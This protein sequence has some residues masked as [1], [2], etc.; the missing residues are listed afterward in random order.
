M[1]GHGRA[2]RD[3]VLE[4]LRQ[5]AG[6]T[7][8]AGILRVISV[9][10]GAVS[11]LLTAPAVGPVVA[12]A[13]FFA[14]SILLQLRFRRTVRSVP[15]AA[16]T[17]REGLLSTTLEHTCAAR[18]ALA[19]GGA[20]ARANAV[21]DNIHDVERGFESRSTCNSQFA[22]L[23][24]DGDKMVPVGT[25]PSTSRYLE[26]WIVGG[27]LPRAS[28]GPRGAHRDAARTL[29]VA[30][31]PQDDPD[32]QRLTARGVK[33]IAFVPIRRASYEQAEGIFF[34]TTGASFSSNILNHMAINANV[35]GGQLAGAGLA[36]GEL[37]TVAGR[38]RVHA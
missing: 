35:L 28:L 32:R 29:R 7:I 15:D 4:A 9:A 8:A 20:P 3:T 37:E 25:A 2:A 22:T 11:S 27:F 26:M 24:S 6:E 5:L 38:R 14:V 34:A 12:A 33:E 21:L 31:L 19:H 1:S 13:A 30:D 18:D 23:V 36:L 16:E 17:E 10:L